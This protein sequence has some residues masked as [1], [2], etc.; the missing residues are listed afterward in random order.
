LVPQVKRKIFVNT[1][2][3]S[4][5]MILKCSN[6]SFGSITAMDCRRDQLKNN[7]FSIQEI[8]EEC[9]TLVVRALQFEAKA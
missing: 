6:C 8:F 4:N 2:E 1:T 7:I 5:E 3:A 9:R